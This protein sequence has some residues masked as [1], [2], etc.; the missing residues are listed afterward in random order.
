MTRWVIDEKPFNV[1][2]E[3]CRASAP[4]LEP[5][6][7]TV[8]DEIKRRASVSTFPW[9]SGLFAAKDGSGQ[10]IIAVHEVMSGTPAFEYL[11]AELRPH[12]ASADKDLVEHFSIAACAH[13][14]TEAV[15]VAEDKGAAFLALSELGRGR[16]ATPFDLWDDLLRRSVIALDD[17]KRLCAATERSMQP[18]RTPVRLRR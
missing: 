15:F 4:M 11:F 18:L 17:F 3:H 6:M 2:A 14:L 9:R 13:D 8:V 12:A 10:Q 1:L 16:V 5:G 7:V